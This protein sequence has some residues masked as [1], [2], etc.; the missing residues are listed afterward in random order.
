[1]IVNNFLGIHNVQ[2]PRSIPNNALVSA[3]DVDINDNGTLLRRYGYGLSKA[4]SVS[5]AYQTHDGQAYLVSNG[6]LVRVLDDLSL[7]DIAASTATEFCDDSRYVFTNDGLKIFKD[8]AYTIN[9]PSPSAPPVLSL[10]AGSLPPGFYTAVYTYTNA[11]GLESGSSYPAV[12]DLQATGGINIQT[13]P[14]AG[15]TVQVYMTDAGGEVFYNLADGAR[16]AKPNQDTSNFPSNADKVALF[17]SR[18]YVSVPF[19]DHTALYW[20]ERYHYHLYDLSRSYIVVPGRILAIY[21]MDTSLFIATDK[22]MYGF[23]G[24]NLNRKA[25]YGVVPGR[26]V[27]KLPHKDTIL[28]HSTRGV[29]Q[30]PDFAN[31]TDKKCSLPTGTTCST[32][33]LNERGFQT[34]LALHDGGEAF[35]PF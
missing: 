23:D 18:L 9:V 10:T 7:V 19:A 28:V 15:H 2:P 21:G 8:K 34:F 12:F 32:A 31:L 1:M 33:I 26:P 14:L 25:D 27:A 5:T 22:E 35:N 4:L 11:D 20:S 29:C 16:L 6:R 30:Y 24:Q 13:E 3:T 17:D